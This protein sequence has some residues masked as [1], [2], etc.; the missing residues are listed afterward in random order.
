MLCWMLHV[1]MYIIM[2]ITISKAKLF[3]SLDP[4]T[5][6]LNSSV[7]VTSASNGIC[8]L[9]GLFNWKKEMMEWI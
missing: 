2:I 1:M 3:V 6:T 8:L 4:E 7:P 9:V 5:I